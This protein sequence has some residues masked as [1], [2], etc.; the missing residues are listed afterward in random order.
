M[1]DGFI[2]HAVDEAGGHEG[3]GACVVLLTDGA[4][5]DVADHAA[6]VG[7]AGATLVLPC[8]EAL[9]DE[10]GGLDGAEENIGALCCGVWVENGGEEVLGV[11]LG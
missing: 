8:L 10:A 3:G 2:W 6:L 4:L 1:G 9:G 7:D 5:R 11:T